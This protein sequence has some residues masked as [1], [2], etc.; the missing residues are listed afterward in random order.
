M[1]RG[2]DLS[3]VR[4][5]PSHPLL[6]E[7]ER[8]TIQRYLYII[9]TF[10]IVFYTA[11]VVATFMFAPRNNAGPYS[12]PLTVMRVSQIVLFAF[13]FLPARRG[14]TSTATMIVVGAMTVSLF[15]GSTWFDTR[16]LTGYLSVF[17][18]AVLIVQVNNFLE[19]QSH[20]RGIVALIL[21]GILVSAATRYAESVAAEHRELFLSTVM[22]TLFIF[23]AV[24]VPS[25]IG[26]RQRASFLTE[27]R[28]LAYVD[29]ITHLRNVHQL[30]IDLAA[31]LRDL[32]RSGGQLALFGLRIHDLSRINQLNGY[33]GGDRVLRQIA[34][35][36]ERSAERYEVYRISGAAFA[37][38][39]TYRWETEDP[40]RIINEL[41]DG[42]LQPLHIDG[43]EWY[44]RGTVVGTIAPHDGSSPSRL[45]QNIHNSIAAADRGATGTSIFW[46]D[47]AYFSQIERVQLIEDALP[48]S[49]TNRSFEMVIQPQYDLRHGYVTGGELLARWDH[50][51]LGPVSPAEFIPAIERAGLMIPF[52]TE[53]L[54][55]G[56]EAATH[57]VEGASRTLTIA[58][59]LSA[60]SIGNPEMIEVIRR[61]VPAF[62]A[63]ALEIEIT[64]DVFL[65]MS[66]NVLAKLSEI[67][68]MG[69]S[70]SLDD[71]GTGFSNF[72]YL[73]NLDVDT[74]K[75]DRRFIAPLP[76]D[77]GSVSIVTAI[78]TMAHSFGL[79]VIAEGV[80]TTEQME[81]LRK[82]GCDVI[83]G[84]H[85][86]RPIPIDRFAAFCRDCYAVPSAE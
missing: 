63:G 76:N 45:I 6:V 60:S 36:F 10:L 19:H 83:Q 40:K 78:I 42:P 52:T 61:I 34:E 77:P 24:A 86:S 62:A 75:I 31:R 8:R 23:I 74:L 3:S 66:P 51:A 11:A 32:D 41:R 21:A 38:L 58:V 26:A 39:P 49:I 82:I 72:E 20:I 37:F 5:K 64:E 71:F 2:N 67:K 65:M 22:A 79:Q 17:A 55:I 15:V 28:L 85:I 30:E 4:E 46:F 1:I 68:S 50:P 53:V 80:E 59:N 13:A 73:Q 69:V 35:R 12:I 9:I 54:R 14:Y 57:I 18:G 81:L 43:K 27:L 7:S 70:I 25:F 48:T 29:G 44:P 16:N 84:Y 47:P 56:A 33:A